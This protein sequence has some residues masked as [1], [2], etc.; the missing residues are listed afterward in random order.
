M[1]DSTLLSRL[2][3]TF[4]A[5]TYES[6]KEWARTVYIN[7]WR[8]CKK[9]VDFYVY[10][11]LVPDKVYWFISEFL[12]FRA[13]DPN[14]YAKNYWNSK[15]DLTPECIDESYEGL[16]ISDGKIKERHKHRIS[17]NG[18]IDRIFNNE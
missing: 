14:R 5:P 12:G 15:T 13:L 18:K 3:C 6:S 10:E 4:L 16:A 8:D 7:E 17:I 11:I 2:Y 9:V 1:N